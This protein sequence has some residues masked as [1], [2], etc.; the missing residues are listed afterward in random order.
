MNGMTLDA[1]P[2]H[3]NG[4]IEV[5]EQGA[6]L[7]LRIGGELDTA[8]CKV[9]EPTI[10]TAIATASSVIIDLAELTFCDSSGVGLFIATNTKAVADGTAVSIRNVRPPV[11]RIFQITNLDAVIELVE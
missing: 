8:S 6:T 5:S 9:I 4:W 7:I 10:T 11:R 1:V 3:V 2:A